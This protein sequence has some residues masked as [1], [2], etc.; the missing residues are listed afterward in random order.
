MAHISMG[1]FSKHMAIN[2]V[3][4]INT[5]LDACFMGFGGGGFVQCLATKRAND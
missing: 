4:G 1:W 2:F 5:I 3:K